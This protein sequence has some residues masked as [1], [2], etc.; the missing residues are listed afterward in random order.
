MKP[1]LSY[2]L[3]LIVLFALSSC[4]SDSENPSPEPEPDV[5]APNVTFNIAGSSNTSSGTTPVFSNQITINIS[6]QDAGGVAKVEAYINDQKV[7]EDVTSPFQI[8]IDLTGY[9]SKIPSSGKFQDYTLKI[10]ATDTSGNQSSSEQVIHIDNELPAITNVSIESGG[11]I[12]G[13]TNLVTFSVSDNEGLKSVKVILNNQL[14]QE[15]TDDVYEFNINTLDLSEGENSFSIEA[16]DLANNTAEFN[17]QFFA[18]NT[19]PEIIVPNLVDGQILDESIVFAPQVQ[20]QFSNVVSFTANLNGVPLL[21]STTDQTGEVLIDPEELAI[22]EVSFELV[23]S[24]ELGNETTLNWTNQV[25]R[26]LFRVQMESDFFENTWFGFHILISEMDGS[27]IMLKSAKITDTELILHAPGE[28]PLDKEYMVSFIAEE[29]QGSWIETHMTVVQNLTRSNFTQINFTAPDGESITQQTIPM[30]G[31]LGVE[32]I[33]GRGH[34]FQ[35][36]HDPNLETFSLESYDGA[37]YNPYNSYYLIG[38]HLGED[39]SYGYLKIDNP[40]DT[41]FTIN[42]SDFIFD[43]INQGTTSFTGNGLSSYDHNL[44]IWGFEKAEDVDKKLSHLIY[45]SNNTFGPIG[46]DN[47]YY[48]TVF[49]EYQHHFRLNNYNTYRNGLPAPE[50][51]LPDWTVE[52]S[53]T[54]NEVSIIKTGLG[55][56]V[57]RLIVEIGS[58]TDGSQLM[59]I[60]FKS[61]HEGPIY[62]PMIPKELSN[63]N[64]YP[65]FQNQTYSVEY[66]ELISFDTI[67]TYEEYLENVITNY[68]EHTEVAPIMESITNRNAF[69]FSNWSYKYQ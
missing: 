53:Q 61:A 9:T 25:L 17:V 55:H 28:F 63:L 35:S 37:G 7:G 60:L 39:P 14:L 56:T 67:T 59:P 30:S 47:Y 6:A 49:E 66:S 64:V 8:V 11:V 19:G 3:L 1:Y 33:I 42:K 31:F 54:G 51:L 29:N 21:E 69:I 22:G 13:D 58:E 4:S 16:I 41:G 10:V 36:T 20:D 62:L 2:Q 32:A 5:V 23:A 43:N 44:S 26:R 48:P 65:I 34:G 12:N 68:K 57:G 46:T 52:H 18:D 24:D 38:Y 50:Y 15:F 45:D 40:W 27:F